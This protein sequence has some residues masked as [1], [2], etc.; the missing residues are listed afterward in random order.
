MKKIVF[1][2]PLLLV[3]GCSNKDYLQNQKLYND[4]L[5]NSS[6]MCEQLRLL[7]NKYFLDNGN[8]IVSI[9][10]IDEYP[11]YEFKDADAPDE[12]DM[13]D[14][15][16]QDLGGYCTGAWLGAPSGIPVIAA[17]SGLGVAI[18]ASV[19]EYEDQKGGIDGG[20]GDGGGTDGDDKKETPYF[21]D[22]FHQPIDLRKPIFDFLYDGLPV[23]FDGIP[24]GTLGWFH[25][26]IV[27]ELLHNSEY[28]MIERDDVECRMRFIA[29]YIEM[30]KGELLRS[31]KIFMD[32]DV[33]CRYDVGDIF[34]MTDMS[35]HYDEIDNTFIQSFS[36]IDGWS[37]LQELYF[38][39][40]AYIP[41]S[42][43]YDY[44]IDY[45]RKITDFYTQGEISD[46][47]LLLINGSISVYLYSGFLWN[48]FIPN[49]NVSNNILV[50][51]LHDEWIVFEGR[52]CFFE[53]LT[54]NGPHIQYVGF[55]NVVDGVVTEIFFF[56]DVVDYLQREYREVSMPDINELSVD[57]EERVNCGYGHD[58]ERIGLYYLIE[59]IYGRDDLVYYS[60]KK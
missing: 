19:S 38:S 14:V 29:E 52:R 1:I 48:D 60:L 58:I 51:T 53:Y 22:G 15:A 44:S 7:K 24:G 11:Q 49:P 27:T 43:R 32:D 2:L 54:S 9:Q 42:K 45:M 36:D 47:E 40:L 8:S 33:L 39:E 17:I 20:G 28:M 35:S 10:Y 16:I 21:Y 57:N 25:N 41:N 46:M 26:V 31:D 55:P 3:L 50:K 5:D 30:Y 4:S 18:Y 6:Q 37:E 34:E 23:G 59:K 12:I 56:Q 13:G